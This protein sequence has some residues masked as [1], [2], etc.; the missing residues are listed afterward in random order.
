MT[1]TDQIAAIRA[2]REAWIQHDPDCFS[3]KWRA[4]SCQCGWAERVR[5]DWDQMVARVIERG[6][7]ELAIDSALL[8]LR[9]TP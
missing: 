2:E 7:S 8:A 4:S 9:G 1:L 5:A 6:Y 3:P